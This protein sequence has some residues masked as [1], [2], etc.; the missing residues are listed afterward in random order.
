MGAW[1]LWIEDPDMEFEFLA[2]DFRGE[3]IQGPVGVIGVIEPP[4]AARDP[5]N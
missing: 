2:R 3:T 5:S 4:T 1:A